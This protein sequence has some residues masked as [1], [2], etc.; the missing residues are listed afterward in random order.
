MTLKIVCVGRMKEPH[1]AAACNEYLKRI[2]R[3]TRA[4]VVELK[5]QSDRNI[6]V[7][8]RKEAKTIAERTSKPADSYKIALDRRGKQTTSEEFSRLLKKPKLTFIIGGPDGLAEEV[9]HKSDQIL[10]LSEM[11]LPHQLARV[12]LLEQAYRGFTIL[13]NEKYHK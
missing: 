3:Y 1:Y 5:E 10:S 6:E 7:A 11:T 9:L 13:N 4:E 8:K 12:F 2:N